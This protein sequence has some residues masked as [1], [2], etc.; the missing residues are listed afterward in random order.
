[1]VTLQSSGFFITLLAIF[2]VSAVTVVCL[3]LSEKIYRL[4]GKVGSNI[5]ARVMAIF[6]AAIG[7][8]FVMQGM[9]HYFTI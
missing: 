6:I 9:T 2:L 4:L 7:I 1:M 8:E 5:F 3:V